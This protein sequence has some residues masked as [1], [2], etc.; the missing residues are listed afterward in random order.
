MKKKKIKYVSMVLLLGLISIY[1]TPIESSASELNDVGL[2]QSD[3]EICVE[4]L[5]EGESSVEIIESTE[6]SFIK[7]FAESKNISYAEAK[8]MNDKNTQQL[9]LKG[10]RSPDEIAKYVT[11]QDTQSV[12]GTAIKTVIA[13]EVKA[14]YN[15]ATRKYTSFASFGNP[16]IRVAGTIVSGR[17]EGSAPN[18]TLTSTKIRISYTGS[19]YVGVTAN[20]GA[21]LGG[22]G[23]SYSATV[24]S[25]FYY[26]SPVVTQVLLKYPSSL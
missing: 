15:R 24:G 13:L 3:L 14:V 1:A 16:Y 22:K 2:E 6:E 5:N 9:N 12:K 25:T 8:L 26:Y 7:S 19:A 17:W 21:Q 18:K 4:D 20:V 23:F 10:T 11:V